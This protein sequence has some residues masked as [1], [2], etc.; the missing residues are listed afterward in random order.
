MLKPIQDVHVL[1]FPCGDLAELRR[2][3][4]IIQELEEQ[5]LRGIGSAEQSDAGGETGLGVPLVK[6]AWHLPR[7]ESKNGRA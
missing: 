7:D 3:L 1:C 6:E 2:E 4:G 5:F